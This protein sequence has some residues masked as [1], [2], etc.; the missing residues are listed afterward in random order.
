MATT[1]TNRQAI[2]R[3][4]DELPDE[5]LE[6]LMTFINYL[7]YRQTHPGSAWFKAAYDAFK[8]VRDAIEESGMSEDE[9]NA[10]IDEAID[11]VRREQDA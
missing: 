8:S 6:E 11:E 1:D 4:I 10:A 5:S 7:H 3:A 9:I 2:H